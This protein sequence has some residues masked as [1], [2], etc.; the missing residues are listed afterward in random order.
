MREVEAK[1]RLEQ[2]LLRQSLT[3]LVGLAALAV[4][5]GIM[6]ASFAILFDGIYSLIDACMGLLALLVSRLIMRDA[7]RIDESQPGRVRYQFGFWHLE[8]MVLALNATLLTLAIL[9]ALGSAL[10]LLVRG[11]TH[12]D[13]GWAVVYAG[14]MALI[15]FAMGLRQRRRNRGLDSAFVALDVKS[16]IMSGSISFALFLAFAVGWS[17]EGTRAQHLQPYVDPAILAL[18]CLVV[19]PMPFSDLR[20]AVRDIFLEAPDDLDA[21]VRQVAAQAVA[22]HGFEDAYTY[23]ARV[24]RSRLIEIHFLVPPGWKVDSIAQ[25]DAIRDSVGAEIGGEGPHRWL[26]ICFTEDAEW[27]F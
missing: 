10:I 19:L 17:L 18:V 11:G 9:Y 27:A 21:H 12:P 8:P 26:T 22:R 5:F 6:T 15:C 16:W 24:G 2:A 23:V 13:F 14:A 3:L 20:T 1:G 7:L 4:G 25:L